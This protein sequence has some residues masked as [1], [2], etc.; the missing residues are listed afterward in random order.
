MKK[1]FSQEINGL[2][3]IDKPTNFSSNQVLQK[4]RCLFNA[5]KAGH[6]GT[7][8]PL[9]TGILPIC[10][11]KATKFSQFLIDSDKR[12]YVIAKLGQKTDTFDSTGKIISE[13]KFF[14]TKKEI[15]NS[16]KKFHGIL[17]QI[18][19]MY[20]AIKYKNKPL[21]KYA[22]KGIIIK[23]KKRKVN[24]YNLKFKKFVNNEL[25]L[26]IFCSKGTYIRTLID[27][28][29]NMLGCGAHVISLRRLQIS[30]YS[31]KNVVTLEQL[32]SIKKKFQSK[33]DIFNEKIEE[34]LYPVSE[35][36]SHFPEINISKFKKI[37]FKKNRSIFKNYNFKKGDIVQITQGK[38]HKLIGVAKII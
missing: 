11:G 14:L 21:Y 24:I 35:L 31:E 27:D 13:K 36:I 33:K 37:I 23:R 9:A 16:L 29:G 10:F 7:L 28:L 34:L 4:V 18:P 19:P 1:K 25:E 5:K 8:D 2:L 26:E 22:R 20:S 15:Q 38:N 12:Y 6:T 17:F 32:Y 3:L 30:D